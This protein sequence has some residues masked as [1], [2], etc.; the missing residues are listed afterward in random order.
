[1]RSRLRDD[2]RGQSSVLGTTV[3]LGFVLLVTT[4][5]VGVGAHTLS[6]SQDA[7]EGQNVEH[8]MTQLDSRASLVALEGAE[9][10]TVDMGTGNGDGTVN[11]REKGW[12]RLELLNTSTGDRT[13][14]MNKSLGAVVYENG[15]EQIAYQGGGVWKVDGKGN[16]T[17]ISP[18]EFKYSQGTITFPVVS[19]QGQATNVE[20]LTIQRSGQE[21]VFPVKG[22]ES[23]SNPVKERALIVTIKS[24]YY[25]GW[26]TYFDN[27]VGGNLT[28]QEADEKLEVELSPPPEHRSVESA[29]VSTSP[30]PRIE[31]SGNGG[32]DGFVKSYNSTQGNVTA[33]VGEDAEIVSPGGVELSGSSQIYGDVITEGDVVLSGNSVIHG[34]ASHQ[35]SVYEHG[36][37]AKVKGWDAKNGTVSELGEIDKTVAYQVDRL[38]EN[39]NNA[40]EDDI[41]SD[42]ELAEG[43][44]T[45][46]DGE[47]Y[48]D[49]V[50]VEEGETLTLDVSDG[51]ITIGVDDDVDVQGE[52]QVVGNDGT[53]NH[54]TI[55]MDD[56]DIDI[57]G[58]E[59]RTEGDEA[60]A[61]W[62]YGPAGTDIQMDNHALYTGVVYAPGNKDKAG[63]VNLQSQSKVYGSIV[64]GKI[65]M[66]SGSQVYFDKALSSET[67]VLKSNSFRI[68]EYLHITTNTV[69][70]TADSDD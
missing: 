3:I 28:V 62:L 67:V 51:N 14:I 38:E 9:S 35:G 45:L 23:L 25:R 2:Q 40:D 42:N 37:N 46:E 66:R 30:G 68:Y 5:L 50:E 58:G 64:G 57:D 43:D 15:D 48:L 54:V 24:D 27:R 61:F 69:E 29:L 70:I 32:T 65:T 55:W 13:T 31:L 52:I 59:V 26:E 41:T 6:T 53:E 60:P 11:V 10:Q 4:S 7:A 36:A 22:N 56:R 18:P 34:N 49:G 44:K 17:M 1:M 63:T 8:S 21:T 39:N 33:S 12:I 19:V 47:Y 20:T 16:A